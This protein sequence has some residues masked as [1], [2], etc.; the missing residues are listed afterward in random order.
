MLL[1]ISGLFLFEAPKIRNVFLSQPEILPEKSS[2]SAAVANLRPHFLTEH[3]QQPLNLLPRTNLLS[4]VPNWNP[5]K[6]IFNHHLP[7]M[8]THGGTQTQIEQ[9]KAA[10]VQLH[11][12]VEPL[13]WWD[14]TQSGDILHHFGRLPTHTM[15]AAQQKG[16]KVVMAPILSHLGAR[17][18]W[19]RFLQKLAIK[20]IRKIG[21]PGTGGAFDWDSYLLADANVALTSYEASLMIEIFGAP[22][23]RVHVMP[24]GVEDV[25]LQSQPVSRG[26]WLVCTAAIIEMKQV[27]KLAQIAVRAKTPLWIIGRAHSDTD[28]YA[29]SFFDFVR[30]HLQIIRYE[31]AVSDRQGLARIYREARGFVLLS[32]WEGLSLSALEAAACQCP[33]LLSDLPWAHDTFNSK[34]TYL[35]HDAPL[36]FSAD[37]LRRF[38]EA[39]P[40]LPD[41]PTPL[42]WL[43][44]GGR[45]KD[46]YASLC[47]TSR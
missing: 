33:L 30:K 29:K 6:V 2:L 47:N 7:F 42:S 26:P 17:P 39:A 24:N 31:G 46:L 36:S 38:Y 12:T 35:R 8:L 44:V 20:S 1:A 28:E 3:F 10:L 19:K 4:F 41:P 40:N 27:L 23:R 15:M 25:F 45:L 21:P 37:V 16:M 22:A 14:E 32:K 13:R 34:A 18:P 9:T 43:E 5:M 11:V